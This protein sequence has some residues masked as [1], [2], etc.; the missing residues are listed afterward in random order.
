M[1]GS[2]LSITD[3]EKNKAAKIPAL[4]KFPLQLWEERVGKGCKLLNK[5]MKKCLSVN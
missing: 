2:I 1:P 5:Q 4:L 3:G